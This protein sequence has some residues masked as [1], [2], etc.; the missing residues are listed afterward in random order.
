MKSFV[1]IMFA[2]AFCLGTISLHAQSDA[3]TTPPWQLPSDDQRCPSKW[4]AGDQRGSGNLMKPDTVLRATKLIRTGEV[5]EL[6]ELLSND[7]KEAFINAGRQFSLYTKPD[8][9]KPNVRTENEEVVVSELGQVGTQIDAYAHQMYGDSFYNC[10]KYSDIAARNGYKK[11]GVE[12]IGTLMSRGVLI[13]V[14][15]LK[16]VD[17]LG[18]TYIITPEDLQQALANEKLTLQPGDAVIIN[19]GYGKLMG[20]DNQ[21]YEKNSPGISIAAGQWLVSQNPMLVA[22]DNCCLEVRPSEAKMSL[23]IHQMFLIQYG[24]HIIENMKLDSLA[25]AHAY[26]FA[27]IVQ[28]LKMKGATG[29]AVEPI[30]IR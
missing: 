26:E 29:S 3:Q 5:F 21:R 12:N 16:G 11:L 30:A 23:P 14:A 4:G 6:G 9:P 8:V 27:F 22:A 18:D 19:T 10:F 25:A 17:M 1:R 7:P 28:P 13:D 24:V 15:A 20:K 2:L